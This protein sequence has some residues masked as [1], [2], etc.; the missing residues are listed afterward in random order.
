MAIKSSEVHLVWDADT[1]KMYIRVQEELAGSCEGC[2]LMT[3]S[4]DRVA[5]CSSII[6]SCIDTHTILKEIN[7]VDEIHNHL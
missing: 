3:A 6:D 4:G 5:P 7:S 2:A 1:K